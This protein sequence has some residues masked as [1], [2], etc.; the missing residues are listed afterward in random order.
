M[1]PSFPHL[2]L[3]GGT[4]AHTQTAPHSLITHAPA[5]LS[6]THATTTTP[7]LEDGWLDRLMWQLRADCGLLESCHIMD[8]S[9][10]LGGW[11]PVAR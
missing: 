9:L 1:A 4:H 6:H 11:G 8:Y 3:C 7:R 2:V 10:L 5:Y